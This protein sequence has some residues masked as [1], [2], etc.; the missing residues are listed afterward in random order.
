MS[1]CN[2]GSKKES[3]WIQDGYGIDLCKVC[4]DC[5]KQ[6]MKRYRPDI[7]TQYECEEP[8]EPDEG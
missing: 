5:K 2:C 1:E 8:I 6:K 4:K 3:Y 7:N